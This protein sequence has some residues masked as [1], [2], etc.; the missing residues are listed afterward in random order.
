MKS[1]KKIVVIGGG[2]GVFT[3]LSGLR[4]HFADLT[5][6][7]TMAD[8]G[9]STG[10][11]REEFGILP[12]GDV[13]RALVALSGHDNAMLAK[14]FNYRFAEGNGLSGHSFGNLMLAALERITGSF[15]R[16]IEEAGNM[17]G[18]E[19]RVL[20]VTL[21]KT[22]LHAELENGKIV[23]GEAN[24][25]VPTHDGR[26]RISRVWLKPSARS[27]PAARAAIMEADAVLI[28]PGD[29]YTSIIPNILVR[30][31]PEALQ[32]TKAKKI[33]VVNLMTKFGET[34]GFAAS[35]FVHTLE[36]YLGENV[37]DTVIANSNTP[38][39]ARLRPYSHEGAALVGVDAGHFPQKPE[40]VRADLLRARGFLRHDSDKLA[41]VVKKLVE[42]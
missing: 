19:G 1:D 34:N 15:P 21:T 22:R 10:V 38:G 30:G 40:L 17:L 5:A 16:A 7:V 8:D 27:T 26:L 9:G 2:T 11:L 13:R 18:V 14:L 23:D 4:K 31:V 33:Y 25:D 32:Q 24:I 35:D 36:R 37:L 6:I 42:G 39:P 20:P 29:L 28:G 3:V 41:R 12:P